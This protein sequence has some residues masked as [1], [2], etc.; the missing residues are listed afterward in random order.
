M[1][2]SSHTARKRIRVL[3]SGSA[4]GFVRRIATGRFGSA[5]G[6]CSPA[7]ENDSSADPRRGAYYLTD[8]ADH[9]G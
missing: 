7:A 9:S 8:V 6:D 5:W 1:N 4:F 2:A 3:L